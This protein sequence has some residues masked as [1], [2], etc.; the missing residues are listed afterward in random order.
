MIKK[1]LLAA[2]VAAFAFTALP[3]LAAAN[4]KLDSP[5]GEFPVP[6]TSHGGKT[7]FETVG[8]TKVVCEEVENVGEFENG[9]TGSVRFHFYGC[10]DGTFGIPCTTEGLGLEEGE[11]TTTTLPFH[12]VTA[13]HEPETH[14]EHAILI[15][16][17]GEK[18][19]TGHFAEFDCS[20]LVHID[21]TGNGIIGTITEPATNVASSRAKIVFQAAGTGVQTHRK[22]TGSET[23]YDL[24]AVING[25][26]EEAETAAQV[27]E[28]E[29]TFEGEA[30]LTDAEP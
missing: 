20:F 29:L 27:G 19:G 17:N 3:A 23:E 24:K 30:T 4:P 9:Q 16:P 18:Y 22:I 8:G 10:H 21:V 25:N 5:N 6:F 11:I 1:S 2:L 12:L 28:G 14:K 15:T 26:H 13:N 7:F